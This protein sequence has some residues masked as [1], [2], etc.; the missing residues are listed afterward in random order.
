MSERVI[1]GIHMDWSLGLSPIEKGFIAIG[2]AELGDLSKIPA[3]RDALKS[4]LMGTYNSKPGAVP[5]N[6]GVL[7]RFVHEMKKGDIVVYPS[8]PDRMVNLGVVDGGYGFEAA[9]SS[10]YPNQRRVKW[11]RQLPRTN[12]SADALHEIGS[13][14]T[15]FKIT[16]NADEFLAA[17]DG[18]EIPAPASDLEAAEAV[19]SQAEESATDFIIKRLKSGLNPYQFEEFVGHLLECMGYHTRV[20][21]KSGDGGIDIIAHRDELGFE[22]PV[23]K[24]QCKQTLNSIGQPDVAQLYGHVEPTEFG[25]FVTLGGFTADG[26]RFE[27]SKRN[28]R[29][30]DGNALVELIFSHYGS[31]QPKYQVLLPLKQIYIPGVVTATQSAL[32]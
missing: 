12:F 13:F 7:F 16:N 1:W 11:L 20:T 5:V 4:S 28:L 9:S 6:A 18:Q 21:Q 2:W 27:R 30:I 3:S 8:K 17:F 29:L 19:S 22:P 10:T 23:I 24:V 25:L 15:L 14:I 32:F 26:R 31:F